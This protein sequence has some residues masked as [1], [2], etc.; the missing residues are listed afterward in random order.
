MATGMDDET[1]AEEAAGCDCGIVVAAKQPE[2]NEISDRHRDHNLD[3]DVKGQRQED[4]GNRDQRRR[5]QRYD[6]EELQRKRTAP[7]DRR[8]VKRM[9]HGIADIGDY[10][11]GDHRR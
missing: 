7:L 1:E 8:E 3:P 9:L 10:N 6:Q 11:A 4:G 5:H 2:Q